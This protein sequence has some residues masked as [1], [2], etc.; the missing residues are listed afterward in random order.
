MLK[1]EIAK[2]NQSA[3]EGQGAGGS[4]KL[5]ERPDFSHNDAGYGHLA[6]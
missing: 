1:V 2:R 6:H 3:M 5:A 4:E